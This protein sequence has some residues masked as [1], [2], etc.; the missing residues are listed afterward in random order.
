M[1]VKARW[2]RTKASTNAT[3]LSRLVLTGGTRKSG[4]DV[5]AAGDACNTETRHVA[6]LPPR[7]SI[8]ITPRVR[9]PNLGG[10][11]ES[12]KDSRVVSN[13]LSARTVAT[14]M[15]NQTCVTVREPRL[16]PCVN[17]AAGIP[18]N[19]RELAHGE[20]RSDILCQALFGVDI[21]VVSI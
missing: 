20:R 11:R 17:L 9:L 5:H 1:N 16:L 21:E 10:K 2:S 7:T 8:A 15:P 13:G 19:E 14:A 4:Y 12:G 3:H 6:Y 18:A